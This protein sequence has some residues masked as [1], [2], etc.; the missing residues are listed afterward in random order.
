MRGTLPI[1]I[2]A[3]APA[4]WQTAAQ[5]RARWHVH[6]EQV[7]KALLYAVSARPYNARS[8]TVCG[9]ELRRSCRFQIAH[10]AV[11]RLMRCCRKDSF[12]GSSVSAVYLRSFRITVELCRLRSTSAVLGSYTYL[13]IFAQTTLRPHVPV[14]L[15]RFLP[16]GPIPSV[17]QP[18]HHHQ[19]DQS[20]VHHRA[21]LLGSH[22]A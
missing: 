2:R 21:S 13:L 10:G 15:I 12:D 14:R 8:S 3:T 5:V 22:S 1:G 16:P 11:S 18:T 4:H 7:H 19:R 17:S 20:V 6:V 9:R